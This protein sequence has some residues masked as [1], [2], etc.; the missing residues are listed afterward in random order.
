MSTQC[1]AMTVPHPDSATEMPCPRGVD[2]LRQLVRRCVADGASAVPDESWRAP[3]RLICDHAR[4]RGARVEELLVS[5]KRTW[6]TL[7]E[8]EHMSRV[9]SPRLLAR[10]VTICVEEYYAPLG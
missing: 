5:L 3:A 8:V 7:T 9:D 2:A 1:L 6:P 10:L 4:T